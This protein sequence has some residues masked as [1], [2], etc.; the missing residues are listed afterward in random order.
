MKKMES[1]E[2]PAETKHAF[3]NKADAIEA[4]ADMEYGP[5]RNQDILQGFRNTHGNLLRIAIGSDGFNAA[6]IGNLSLIFSICTQI[7]RWQCIRDCP[8]LSS[9]E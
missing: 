4:I 9:L 6:I 7:Y 8:M 5:V 2:A 3:L 1:I